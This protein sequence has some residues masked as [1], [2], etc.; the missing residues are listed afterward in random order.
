MATQFQSFIPQHNFFSPIDSWMIPPPPSSSSS[1]TWLKHPSSH[2]SSSSSLPPPSLFDD[3]DWPSP[4]HSPPSVL[5][6]KQHTITADRFNVNA[7]IDPWQNLYHH[8][9]EVDTADT[10]SIDDDAPGQSLYK[11]EL[12]RSFVETGNCRYGLKCQFAHGRDELRTVTRHPKYKTEIC[13]TFHTLGT[14]PYGTRCR[15][16]HTKPKDH[17]HNSSLNPSPSRS[18]SPSSLSSSSSTSPS[19]SPLASSPIEQWTTTWAPSY[20]PSFPH[21]NGNKKFASIP[22]PIMPTPSSPTKS[23]R[24]L[25]IFRNLC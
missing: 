14:C 4:P 7:T 16:I 5:L 6:G 15:F 8:N 19:T 20:L 11:T 10:C 24:R 21:E 1:S 2:H 25:P 12:C 22:T 23:K 13:K 17:S 3:S 9:K 18:D